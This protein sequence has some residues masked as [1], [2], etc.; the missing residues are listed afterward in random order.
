MKKRHIIYMH[1]REKGNDDKGK[2]ANDGNVECG[3]TQYRETYLVQTL[4]EYFQ[5]QK[6]HL[7]VISFNE[8]DT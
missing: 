4:S 7:K 5:T 3:V 1:T 6:P 8:P 2:R